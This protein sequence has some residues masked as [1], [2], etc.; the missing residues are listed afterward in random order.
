MTLKAEGLPTAI[1]DQSPWLL[2]SRLFRTTGRTA[3]DGA[4]VARQQKR[5]DLLVESMGIEPLIS[6]EAGTAFGWVIGWVSPSC[7]EINYGISICYI[8]F[9]A[10]AVAAA[11]SIARKRPTTYTQ[12]PGHSRHRVRATSARP[13]YF[14]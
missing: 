10:D 1:S 4:L 6:A 5:L 2:V 11:L 13:L 9:L 8:L 3:G 12:P 14:I 7:T